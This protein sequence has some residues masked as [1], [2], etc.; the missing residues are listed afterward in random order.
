MKCDKCGKPEERNWV[1]R[2]ARAGFE[3]RN[4]ECYHCEHG[5]IT[6]GK[7]LSGQNK[8]TDGDPKAIIDLLEAIRGIL[9]KA[10]DT[11]ITEGMQ[12]LDGIAY[13]MHLLFLNL[14]KINTLLAHASDG[15]MEALDQMNEILKDS[16]QI[17]QRWEWE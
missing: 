14:V 9:S 11:E 2:L 8:W 5:K 17:I 7:N 16:S 1:L 10:K 3:L 15:K 4:I 12:V 13:S 6:T